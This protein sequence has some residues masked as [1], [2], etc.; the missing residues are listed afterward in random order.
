L[1]WS[2]PRYVKTYFESE[3]VTLEQIRPT[4][5]SHK[6]NIITTKADGMD[7]ITIQSYF[8]TR[9]SVLMVPNMSAI[10]LIIARESSQVMVRRLHTATSTQE[11]ESVEECYEWPSRQLW[12]SNFCLAK[13]A[14]IGHWCS[15]L[16]MH[17]T[18][19]ATFHQV[20]LHFTIG[21]PCSFYPKKQR[22]HG[23]IINKRYLPQTCVDI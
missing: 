5:P 22:Q 1:L 10:V 11:L 13:H 6:I 18:K 3:Q 21:Y 9:L 12:H 2:I 17:E 15:H 20:T 4:A 14:P 19:L 7:A 16:F 23:Q 8:K